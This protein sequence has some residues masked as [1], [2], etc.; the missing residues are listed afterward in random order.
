VKIGDY[1]LEG[2]T[3]R[4]KPKKMWKDVVDKKNCQTL[5]LNREDYIVCSKWRKLSK[6]THQDSD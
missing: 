5:Q 6:Y 1:A 4:G 3:P 2:F